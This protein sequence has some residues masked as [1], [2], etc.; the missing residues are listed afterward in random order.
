MRA[1]DRLRG[2]SAAAGDAIRAGRGETVGQRKNTPAS[3]LADVEAV[4]PED[5]YDLAFGRPTDAAPAPG[6]AVTGERWVE[7]FAPT[8]DVPAVVDG[9][10]TAQDS[11]LFAPARPRSR[12]AHRVD[13]I[14]G[15]ASAPAVVGRHV[16]DPA[17]LFIGE[18]RG[19]PHPDVMDVRQGM[20][21]DC[22][23][24]AAMQ[25]LAAL[26]P[27]FITRIVTGGAGQAQVQLQV[28]G[29]D[30][31]RRPQTFSVPVP[32]VTFRGT[33]QGAGFRVAPQPEERRYWA[34]LTGTT[35]TVHREDRHETAL[36]VRVLEL[37]MAQ[38]LARG[39]ALPVLDPATGAALSGLRQLNAGSYPGAA[40]ALLFGDEGTQTSIVQSNGS[41]A[42]IRDADKDAIA[43]L[44]EHGA[45]PRL[46]SA[47]AEAGEEVGGVLW[48]L[49]G[50]IVHAESELV[51]PSFRGAPD[52]LLALK[53][54]LIHDDFTAWSSK[55]DDPALLAKL[56]ADCAEVANN[57]QLTHLVGRTTPLMS[58][59]LDILQMVGNV[60][61]GQGA[62]GGTPRQG[63][64]S[65]HSYTVL[66]AHIL[67]AGRHPVPAPATPAGIASVDPE[68]SWIELRNP[69]GAGAPN[70]G[71]ARSLDARDPGR[72]TL[73]LHK[74][75]NAF[76]YVDDAA[77]PR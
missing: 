13:T 65:N 23:A 43:R 72:F 50:A 53:L 8:S 29:A 60:D 25:E 34:E 36:W 70:D 33:L 58:D 17:T 28:P 73:T 49:P 18:S 52:G 21:G 2:A 32:V 46:M 5:A 76:T 41:A 39:R 10:K 47:G 61:S 35:L 7:I 26:R 63:L 27:A 71:A 4:A 69:W 74:F 14:V 11:S 62:P 38:A 20:V 67:D 44:I 31:H 42:D 9:D 24:L 1:P 57:R 59:L 12:G 6:P 77:A 64:M 56:R 48:R 75:L 45:H 40:R 3:V 22:W 15:S 54:Q 66:A 51:A 19:A 30:G 68:A 37:A 16:I 55:R